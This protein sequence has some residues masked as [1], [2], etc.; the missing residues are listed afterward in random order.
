MM[1][2]RLDAPISSF[3]AVSRTRLAQDAEGTG[4]ANLFDLAFANFAMLDVTP[5]IT[6]RGR[7]ISSFPD[8]APFAD[9]MREEHRRRVLG[10][11]RR[12][13]H[14]SPGQKEEADSSWSRPLPALGACVSPASV[15]AGGTVKSLK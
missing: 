4:Q 11:K 5:Q 14:P 8:C 9:E 15:A 7:E 10:E 6:N 12:A 2:A 13:L 3:S 1:A